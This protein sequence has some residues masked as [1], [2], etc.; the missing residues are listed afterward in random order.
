MGYS[1]GDSGSIDN[2][3]SR[4]AAITDGGSNTFAAYTYLGSGT[5][6]N[7]AHPGVTGGL[8]LTLEA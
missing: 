4:V 2:R 7:T 8:D 1:Y 3:L 6:I 5:I